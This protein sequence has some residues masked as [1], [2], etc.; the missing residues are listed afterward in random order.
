MIDFTEEQIQRYSRHILLQ[1]V[2]VE[3]QEKI[4]NARVLVVGA[5]GLGAPVS[6]YLAAAGIGTIGRV[7]LIDKPVRNWNISE[8]VFTMRPNT[9][10]P[11]TFLYL[12][13]LD[14]EI[15]D[16]CQSNAHGC[17]QKGIRMADLKA[18]EV[19]VPSEEILNSFGKVSSN[20]IKQV[21]NKT[22]QI[23]LLAEARDRLLPKLMS[24]EKII[25]E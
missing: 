4:M 15:Q 25:Y 22:S 8:S 12:V 9:D 19:L 1:D 23:H 14:K 18:F 16:Y 20:L 10:I 11:S 6:L 17:A 5:G 21:K 3:G 2:G 24:G 13:L 7:Y